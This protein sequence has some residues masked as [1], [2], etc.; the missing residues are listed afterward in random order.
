M[1]AEDRGLGGG[2]RGE[3]LKSHRGTSVCSAQSPN[4]TKQ[5]RKDRIEAWGTLQLSAAF[6]DPNV[7]GASQYQPLTLAA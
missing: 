1:K 3:A 7:E 2:E 5:G 6:E 4:W